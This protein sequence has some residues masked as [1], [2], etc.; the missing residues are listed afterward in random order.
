[1][2]YPSNYILIVPLECEGEVYWFIFLHLTSLP[3]C[4]RF[5]ILNKSFQKC[6]SFRVFRYGVQICKVRKK[7]YHPNPFEHFSI[8]NTPGTRYFWC[9]IYLSTAVTLSFT[10]KKKTLGGWGCKNRPPSWN[11]VNGFQRHM[12]WNNSFVCV[13]NL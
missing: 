6:I 13:T 9:Q 4:L 12:L 5:L 3:L 2:Q 7:N 10:Q 8:K 11:G 1:M